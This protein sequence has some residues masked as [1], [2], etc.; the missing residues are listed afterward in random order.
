LLYQSVSA[1]LAGY[2]DASDANRLCRH[3]AMR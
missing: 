2:E 1:R 3:S